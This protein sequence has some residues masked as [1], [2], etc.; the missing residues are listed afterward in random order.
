MISVSVN[1]VNAKRKHIYIV[2]LV[3]E[4][5]VKTVFQKILNNVFILQFLSNI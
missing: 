4:I 3:N 2:F 1:V 5:Y